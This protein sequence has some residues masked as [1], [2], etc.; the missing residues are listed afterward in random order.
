M[1]SSFASNAWPS[2]LKVGRPAD[3]DGWA[4]KR[5]ADPSSRGE[6]RDVWLLGPQ[7]AHNPAAVAMA[8]GLA[9]E[10]LRVQL[11]PLQADE[12]IAPASSI[13]T[14]GTLG[15]ASAGASAG[16]DVGLV[17]LAHPVV[18]HG[19]GLLRC[20]ERWADLPFAL[21]CTP[22]NEVDHVL[23]LEWGM[24]DVMDAQWS[25]PVVAA[26]LRAVWRRRRAAAAPPVD[27]QPSALSF[28]RLHL[29]G[30]E[31]RVV[32][33][34][35]AVPLTEGE[36]EVLWLLARHAGT[37]VARGDILRRVRGL[38]DQ[39]LDRSIDS[40]IYRIR[41]KL[42]DTER[43]AQRIRTVRNSGYVFMPAGW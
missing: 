33:A 28:G 38:E 43:Q 1:T 34:G 8:D 19:R 30:F 18:E 5:T 31:R 37:A 24:D 7:P 41:A 10:G 21:A 15:S 12:P 27:P 22:L 2:M 3:I 32:H 16:A 9:R 23:A 29:D 11:R 13:A 6:C 26:R 14:R 42:G 17:W 20:R 4:P 39:P 40:R 36:F 25:A 35:R